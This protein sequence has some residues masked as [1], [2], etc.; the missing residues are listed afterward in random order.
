LG[1]T[2][3]TPILDPTVDHHEDVLVVDDLDGVDLLPLRVTRAAA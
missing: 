1:Y 2:P 3:G